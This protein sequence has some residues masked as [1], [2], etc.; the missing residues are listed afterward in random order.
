MTT[1]SRLT[2]NTINEL[3]IQPHL[4]QIPNYQSFFYT[5]H[6]VE[7]VDIGRLQEHYLEST[8]R[9]VKSKY[10]LLT[11]DSFHNT[12]IQSYLSCIKR[13]VDMY[14]HLMKG[15]KQLSF[16]GII[17]LNIC[18]NNIIVK[19]GTLPLLKGFEHATMNASSEH[20]LEEPIE[21]RTIRFMTT[22]GLKSISKSNILDIC[23]DNLE[24]QF[25]LSSF[26]NKPTTYM[27]DWLKECSKTWNV[28]ALN[29]LFLS[30]LHQKDNLFVS[31]WIMCLKKGIA[32]TNRG[33]PEYF[34]EETKALLYLA[35]LS[36]LTTTPGPI[37]S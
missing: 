12:P 35:E 3:Q 16:A 36:D 9:I 30:W 5:F 18:L 29:T 1:T 7:P 27:L 2:L 20:M 34:I 33:T 17:H 24:E 13:Y 8:E 31:K 15:V 6:T 21:C 23:G 28:Y 14:L 25:F 32:N 11:S 4:L 22:H 26:V 19:D 10:V 37:L